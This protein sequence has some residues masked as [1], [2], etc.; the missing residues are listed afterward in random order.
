MFKGRVNQIPDKPWRT[1][2]VMGGRGSGK[3]RIGAEWV[4]GFVMGLAPFSGPNVSPIALVGETLADVRDVMIEGPA[5][6]KKSIRAK[7]PK[8]YASKRQ[9]VWDNG[10]IAQ[11]FSSEDPESLRGPQF[12]AA[13]CDEIGKWKNAVETWDM[14]QFGL[15]LGNYPRVLA[16]TTPR[17]TALIKRLVADGSVARTILKTSENEAN[18]APGFVKAVTGQYGGT[19]LGRQELDG[20]LV[21]DR[22]DGLWKREKLESYQADRPQNL[23]RIVIGLDPPASSG[24]GSASC[25]IVAAGLDENGIGWV[26][27]DKTM[28]AAAP[29]QW[30][31]RAVSL[32]HELKADRIIA[33]VNQGGEMV[34]AVISQIDP[35]VAVKP[36]YASRGKRARAEPVN[37]LYQQDR[38]RHAGRFS[39][40]EDEM[41][42]FGVD[43]LS[44]GRSPDRLDALV[45]ALTELMLNERGEPRIR[46]FT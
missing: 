33:E 19:H 41:C 15:R 46:N 8:F 6:I 31:R 10:A 42:D 30:A 35:S 27:A 3:T 37:M 5:G 13:W 14:L 16:T 28:R 32:Y 29:P 17:S 12:A 38:V 40:L 45:W 43:G 25:G 2:L 11:V 9:L 21:E 4:N 23:N 18:L 36:V 7:R 20:E 1:W 22:Q 34:A 44:D 26:L 39:E 24:K